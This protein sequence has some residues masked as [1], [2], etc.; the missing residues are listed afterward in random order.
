MPE[1]VRTSTQPSTSK[2]IK[3]SRTDERL[4]LSC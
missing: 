2:A 3:A 1:P 4:T